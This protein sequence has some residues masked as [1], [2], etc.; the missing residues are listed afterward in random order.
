LTFDILFR[1]RSA[2]DRTAPGFPHAVFLS[3]IQTGFSHFFE[4]SL[5]FAAMNAGLHGGQ[6]YFLVGAEL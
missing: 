2:S 1:F 3:M 4:F 5:G 6:F